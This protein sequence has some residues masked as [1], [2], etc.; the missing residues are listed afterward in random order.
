MRL[1]ARC[2]SALKLRGRTAVLHHMASWQWQPRER[3]H[4]NL[5]ICLRGTGSMEIAG[6][7]H[8]V[9]PGFAVLI[10]PSTPVR[11]VGPPGA[12]MHNIGL[13]FNM[14]QHAAL[15]LRPWTDRS[16]EI[17]QLPLQRELAQYLQTLLLDPCYDRHEAEAVARQMLRIFLRELDR[18]LED[19]VTRLI[20]RQAGEIELDPGTDRGVDFLARKA[21]LSTS[22]YTRRFRELFDTTPARFIIDRRIENARR[23]LRETTIGI[24]LIARQLGYRD[25]AF[26]SRQFKAKTGASPR[27]HRSP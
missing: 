1:D 19:S 2:L 24:D 11:A 25:Q 20:R 23:L 5:W 8:Q 21:G 17:H 14:P 6:L 16:A 9:R 26:F 12:G 7:H 18:P 10:A 3:A 22:Q 27:Q 13:H 4:H 15:L